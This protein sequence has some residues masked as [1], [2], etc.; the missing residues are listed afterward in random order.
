LFPFPLRGVDFDNDSAFM[1][2]P[3]VGW[4]RGRGLQVT[5]SRAYHKNDQA[6]VEQKNGAI[7]RR[8]VGYG[9]L[10]GSAAARSLAR[11]YAAARLHGNLFQPSFKLKEKK[12]IGARVIKRYHEPASPMARVLAHAA[13]GE[14]SKARLRRL[15]GQADPV[16]LLAE[17]RAAQAELGER[18]DRR[19]TEP[20]SQPP[21][22]VDLDRFAAGLKTAWRAGER[23]PTHRRPYRRRKPVPQRPSMLDGVRD[24]IHAWL[25]CDPTLSA[26]AILGRLE[27]A[28]AATFTDKHLRTVQRAVKTWRGEQARRIIAES[29]AAIAPAA[30]VT[31]LARTEP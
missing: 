30:R 19:G 27:T 8:L 11:L 24:Q 7:V 23:R 20:A 12:R 25:A 9:R 13:V 18:V 2:E 10:E 22:V 21:I 26:V 31:G 14:D 16:L 4:C 29:A 3:V 17:I 15:Y 1:N 6:W 5:R 28:D